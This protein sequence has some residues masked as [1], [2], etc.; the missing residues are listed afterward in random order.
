MIRTPDVEVVLRDY[1]AD[2]GLTAP[3]HVLDVVEDRIGRQPQRRSWRLPWRPFMNIYVKAAA[4][5][6]A[7][8]IVAVV[9]YN[10]LLRS[11]GSGGPAT[12]SPS[13]TAAPAPTP[14][15]VSI[16][17]VPTTGGPLGPGEWR[18][19]ITTGSPS[20]SVVAAIPEGWLAFEDGGGFENRLAT[21]SP[22]S[23]LAILFGMPSHGVFSDPCHWDLAGNGTWDQEGDI[24]V[25]PKVADLVAALHANTSFTSSAPSPVT[26]GPYSGLQ[27]EL[28]FPTNLDPA[29]CDKQQGESEGRYR[30]MPDGIYSQG[31]ANIW[32][33]AIIDVAGTRVVAMIEYFPGTAPDKLAEAQA[34]VDSFEFT[35]GP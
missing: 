16:R 23:G 29:T 17:D 22:P 6:A 28:R 2:D 31:K 21:N 10:L 24:V 9:G 32:R 20:L 1:F 12:P 8:L 11:G 14:T 27:L 4:G 15:A 5:L 13:P 19:H 26:F 25:G 3:D 30:V 7:A 34:I 33:M 18:T 35:P